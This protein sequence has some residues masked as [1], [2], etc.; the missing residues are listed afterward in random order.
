M[1]II[2]LRSE[3]QI[4][5]E[6]ITNG[7]RILDLG[8]GNGAF[9][10]ALQKEKDVTGYGIEIDPDNIVECISKNVKVIQANLDEG[11][12][13]FDANSFDYV[14]MTQTIQ[15]MRFPHKVINEMLRIG[16]EVIVTFP[17]LGH[18]K[19]RL[20][21]L[22]G[23]IPV[24]APLPNSWFETPNIHICTIRDFEKLCKSLGI[25]ILERAILDSTHK[26]VKTMKFFPN[27]F[28]EVAIYRTC[29]A[30][31]KPKFNHRNL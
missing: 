26:F 21:L 14:V 8:C 27:F 16:R 10:A 4:I 15:A 6:W 23:N 7:A 12:N 28:G 24:T 11:L 5:A 22:N 25:I 31:Y 18:W 9:L 30:T 2:E 19:H 29:K 13:G 1:K 20:K 17:N 3:H